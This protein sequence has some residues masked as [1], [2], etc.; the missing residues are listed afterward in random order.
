MNCKK[1]NWETQLITPYKLG[2]VC[3]NCG[4]LKK[5]LD[6]LIE[7]EKNLNC[8]DCG[9]E[10]TQLTINEWFC[11][12]FECPNENTFSY[13]GDI[14]E[15]Q[16]SPFTKAKFSNNSYVNLTLDI[17]NLSDEQKEFIKTAGA[18]T[19]DDVT[20]VRKDVVG[21]WMVK[22]TEQKLQNN[23]DWKLI[24]KELKHLINN[25]GVPENDYRGYPSADE[26]VR[27]VK[28]IIEHKQK[29]NNK[30]ENKNKI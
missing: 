3:T 11:G 18:I 7:K 23:I 22:F 29:I 27:T 9:R 10:L 12:N 21:N 1:H 8:P 20:F 28:Y 2:T 15:Q 19:Y 5:E 16:K 14:L 26:I 13:N 24:E 17:E 6:M 30:N 25:W 4:I